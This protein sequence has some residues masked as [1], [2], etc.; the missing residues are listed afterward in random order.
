MKRIPF[1]LEAEFRGQSRPAGSFVDRQTSEVIQTSPQL[2]FE[3]LD[4]AGT[5]VPVEFSGQQLD[6][7]AGFNWA[8]L[9]PGDRVRLYG[10]CVM[11]DRGSDQ[12]SYPQLA[13]AEALSGKAKLVAAA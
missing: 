12:G 4:P 10:V 1:D 9:K 11:Q 2:M 5:I 6:K 13:G 3:H 8:E 7:V